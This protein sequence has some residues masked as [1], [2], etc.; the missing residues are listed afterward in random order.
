MMTN[1]DLQQFKPLSDIESSI[2]RGRRNSQVDFIYTEDQGDVADAKIFSAQPVSEQ[3]AAGAAAVDTF[4]PRRLSEFQNFQE[5]TQSKNQR[6]HAQH[7]QELRNYQFS[8][9]LTLKH[10]ILKAIK[11][12][13]RQ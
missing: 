12:A 8:L 4:A 7:L 11:E 6:E 5:L 13:T 10:D 1:K 9:F 2:S 3:Q